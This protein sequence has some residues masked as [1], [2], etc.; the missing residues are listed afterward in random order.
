MVDGRSRGT[1]RALPVWGVQ[2]VARIR[3]L[4]KS[5]AIC[6]ALFQFV[7][8]A[9]LELDT[10]ADVRTVFREI[11]RGVRVVLAGVAEP[12]EFEERGDGRSELYRG[13]DVVAE[14]VVR[15]DVRRARRASRGRARALHVGIVV[16]A[17]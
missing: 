2:R 13:A 6:E 15:Q 11:G 1:P 17:A 10:Q 4:K 8:L 12:A 3:L 9:R 5:P 16:S 14:D 7:T